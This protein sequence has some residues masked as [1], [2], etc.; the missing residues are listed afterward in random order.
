M[1]PV[2]ISSII[3]L[4][5]HYLT[6][7]ILVI[8]STP[9]ILNIYDYIDFWG[10]HFTTKNSLIAIIFY[11][12]IL[13]ICYII[14]E[15]WSGWSLF[16]RF[17]TIIIYGITLFI[18]LQ[19]LIGLNVIRNYSP[20]NLQQ[21]QNIYFLQDA[22]LKNNF[23]EVKRLIALRDDPFAFSLGNIDPLQDYKWLFPLYWPNI[24]YWKN[25]TKLPLM[26]E[27]P[28]LFAFASAN[29]TK[30][31]TTKN[32]LALR[33]DYRHPKKQTVLPFN[34]Q[35][36]DYLLS[37]TPPKE[38]R[39]KALRDIT[40]QGNTAALKRLLNYDINLTPTIDD[41]TVSITYCYIDIN[42]ILLKRLFDRSEYL[43]ETY[44]LL[45]SNLG[46]YANEYG[47]CAATL[48]E[49]L[50]STQLSLILSQYET[51][52]GQKT[53]NLSGIFTNY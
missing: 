49:I 27:T 14:V 3:A 28:S 6:Y 19:G 11:I 2:P 25:S 37:L 40:L 43:P 21:S 33:E 48:R 39:Q 32:V 50:N 35:I 18:T 53:S 1:P 13:L 7:K 36:F 51:Y 46:N 38:E 31:A 47:P 5:I 44:K 10:T 23:N 29:A 8:F 52:M 9:N 24:L 17:H 41:I 16:P 30:R 20:Y 15:A 12:H 26:Y 45:N 4:F 34:P 22:I 42:K